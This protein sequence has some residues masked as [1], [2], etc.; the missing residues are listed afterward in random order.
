VRYLLQRLLQLVAVAFGMSIVMFT[1][2]QVLPTDPAVAAL[3][4]DATPAMVSALREEMGL[5]RSLPEQYARFLGRLARLDLGASLVT[6]R[7][8]WDDL[9]A[10]FPAT[11][12]LTLASLLVATVAGVPLG[13]LSA[14]RR[15]RPVDHATRLVSIF[16]AAIPVFWFGLVLQLVFY[17]N[18]GWLPASGRLSSEHSAFLLRPITGFVLVDTLLRWDLRAFGDAVSHLVLPTIALAGLTLAITA[19]MTRSAVLEVLHEPHVTVATAK[20]LR[21]RTILWRHV[22]RNAALPIV[23]VLGLRLGV[24]LGGSVLTETVFS[25]PGIGAYAVTAMLNNDIFAVVGFTMSI[26]IFYAVINLCVDLLYPMLDPR[27]RAD[28]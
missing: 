12:E 11:M 17:G 27:V 28:A 2:A 3:G 8:V 24:L 6:R 23:T 4:F 19:R 16:G 21:R 9:T 25:W 15:D 5:D 20:G 7:P 1:I 18:L 22:L 26:S 13:I 14:V 10:R